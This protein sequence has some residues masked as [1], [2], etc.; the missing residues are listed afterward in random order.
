MIEAALENASILYICS[1]LAGYV[2]LAL[3]SVNA[4]LTFGQSILQFGTMLPN[5]NRRRAAAAAK[6]TTDIRTFV[7]VHVPT[8]EEPPQLVI[9]TLDHLARLHG[10]DFEV[11]VIDN[12]TRDAAKWRP[13]AAAAARLGPR[14]RFYHFENVEGAK[15]GAL[16]LA[17]DLVDA[18]TTH[19]AIVDADYQVA[20]DFLD[21]A[22]QAIGA[23]HVD[24][25][26]FPQAYRGVDV[27]A[28][29]VERELGDYFGCFAAAADRSGSLLP[30]GTLSV[31]DLAALRGVGG[32]STATITE[33]AEIGV[34]LHASGRRGLWLAREAGTG[35]LPIDFAG[36]RTQRARW[37]AG[38]VQ[39][40]CNI[41]RGGHVHAPTNEQ[42]VVIGQ[43]TAWVSLWLV[44]A[45]ALLVAAL[46]PGLAAAHA[47]A[48]IAAVTITGSALLTAIRM[49]LA[50]PPRNRGWRV[51][52]A[53]MTTKL[54][55][56]WTAAI[57]WLPALLGRQMPFHR[58]LKTIEGR[59]AGRIGPLF[60]ASLLFFGIAMI[61]AVRGDAIPV[62]AC[63][64]L[65]SI[66][67]CSL[68][69]DASLRSAAQ[70]NCEL[71]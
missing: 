38:N 36:L 54:A 65:A 19:V 23:H 5:A 18:R 60:G 21:Y 9:D 32:W 8:H 58:T 24:Y 52:H 46:L 69:V 68:L 66:W 28:R 59:V 70:R 29:G 35:L 27:G 25:V 61:Y 49:F 57:A 67:P 42:L 53:A 31:F 71:V 41:W 33:D 50:M 45:L 34:K 47:I 51:W 44:P 15:A 20:P 4:V 16:N 7:S 2:I 39:V 48:S 11:L 22:L 62:L 3:V 26:Q 40:L 14:F 37:V 13:V 56:T 30:T 12:N 10:P 1:A 64:L 17:L 6:L 55:L 63:S 43:L